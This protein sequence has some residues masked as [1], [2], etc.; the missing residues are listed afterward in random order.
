M[1]K[2]TPDICHVYAAGTIDNWNYM[3]MDKLAFSLEQL[4]QTWYTLT[5]LVKEYSVSRPYVK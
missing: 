2:G 1:M 4:F 3:I 5:Y